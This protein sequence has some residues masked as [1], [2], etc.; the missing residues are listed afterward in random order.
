MDQPGDEA[1]SGSDESK[2]QQGFSPVTGSET[3]SRPRS[4][5]ATSRPPAGVARRWLS[6]S[7]IRPG[8]WSGIKW[9]SG[10]SGF[11]P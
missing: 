7:P 10:P 9:V 1:R 6:R 8:R 2:P 3:V 5:Q 4:V 11:A